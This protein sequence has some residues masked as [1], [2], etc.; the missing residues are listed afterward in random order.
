M[1][2]K[3]ENEDVLMLLLAT[4]ALMYFLAGLVMSINVG[5]IALSIIYAT[6]CLVPLF[7][8]RGVY[9]ITRE[10]YEQDLEDKA[11]NERLSRSISKLNNLT[12]RLNALSQG[13]KD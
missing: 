13:T 4:S 11:F 6:S 5:E 10:Q 9:R 2:I 12:E 7:I 8:Y 1:K 3:I